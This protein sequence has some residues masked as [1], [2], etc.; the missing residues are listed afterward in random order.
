MKDS[1]T[2]RNIRRTVI[3]LVI[4]TAVIMIMFVYSVIRQ[5]NGG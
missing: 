5:G 3:A 2:K 1:E 4:L